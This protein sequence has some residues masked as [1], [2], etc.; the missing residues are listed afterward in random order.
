M[1]TGPPEARATVLFHV[2]TSIEHALKAVIMKREGLNR[3]P[4]RTAP[5]NY[6]THDL[7]KLRTKLNLK[8]DHA[9]PVA[10]NWQ[11]VITWTRY[12]DY[13]YD[14]KPMPKKV[15]ASYIEAAYGPD[16]VMQWVLSQLN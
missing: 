1:L 3:W 9:S 14:P 8:L 5:G 4:D 15:A 13:N 16:G 7:N 10:P 2:G 6:W 12:E 11:V